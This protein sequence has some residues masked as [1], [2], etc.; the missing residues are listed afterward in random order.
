MLPPSYRRR[1]RPL[2]FIVFVVAVIVTISD[3]FAANN[4]S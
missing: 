3:A 1:R 2:R 4:F